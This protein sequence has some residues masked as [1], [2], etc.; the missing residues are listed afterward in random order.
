MGHSSRASREFSG[1]WEMLSI[2]GRTPAKKMK[3]IKKETN[4]FFSFNTLPPFNF[5]DDIL[6]HFS[7]S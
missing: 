3:L 1:L 7:I 6:Y 5:S 2:I 4:I